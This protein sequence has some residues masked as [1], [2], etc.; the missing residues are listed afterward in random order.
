[1][2]S[3]CREQTR[4]ASYSDGKYTPAQ[5]RN[6]YKPGGSSGI[7]GSDGPRGRDGAKGPNGKSGTIELRIVPKPP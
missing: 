3:S 1:M 6:T 2:G 7:R 5:Y 4:A